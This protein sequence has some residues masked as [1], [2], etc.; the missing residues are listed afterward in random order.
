VAHLDQASCYVRH[1]SGLD[2]TPIVVISPSE[3][4]STPLAISLAAS[5]VVHALLLVVLTLSTGNALTE[6]SPNVVHL[7]ARLVLNL[8]GTAPPSVSKAAATERSRGKKIAQTI[9]AQ[10]SATRGAQET[11]TD[12]ESTAIAHAGVV[13]ANLHSEMPELRPEFQVLQNYRYSAREPTRPPQLPDGFK[14]TYPQAA[15]D[16]QAEGIVLLWVSVNEAGDIL[17]I[18]DVDGDPTFLKAAQAQLH[19]VRMR[20]ADK[21]GIP[22][23]EPVFLEIEF[24]LR[25]AP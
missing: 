1:S 12:R 25:L 23:S 21:A 10:S 2:Q 18:R 14:F 22:I 19:G 13:I 3:Q 9:A 7:N 5:S 6:K 15:I 11:S 20:P 17:E 4:P 24:R 8:P 16:A